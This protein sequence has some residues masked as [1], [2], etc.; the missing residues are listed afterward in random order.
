T[1]RERTLS[2]FFEQLR[3]VKKTRVLL[4]LSVDTSNHAVF[5]T[6]SVNKPGNQINVKLTCISTTL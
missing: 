2:A 5:G 1:G 6:S 3:R 4:T